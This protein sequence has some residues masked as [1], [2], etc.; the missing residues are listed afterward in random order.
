MEHIFIMSLH[1]T[2]KN[3]REFYELKN[4]STGVLLQGQSKYQ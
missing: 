3:F 2:E 4:V 1:L